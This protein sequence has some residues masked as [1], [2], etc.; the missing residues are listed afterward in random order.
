MDADAAPGFARL[1]AALDPAMAIVT[2]AAG[3]ERSGCLVGFHSQCGIDPPR[4]AVW[5]S[6]ANHTYDIGRRA[7]LFAV[8]FPPATEIALAR[9]FGEDTGDDMDKFTRCGWT[10]GPG[11]VPLLDASPVRFVGRALA[12]GTVDA[13]H[14]CLVLE[15]IEVSSADAVAQF[16]PMRFDAVADLHAG[17]APDE[18]RGT[19]G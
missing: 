2:T 18:R 12:L 8:H 10:P 5:L 15:P 7:E 17:H 1:M 16:N 4:Y 11:D 9:L 6:V 14:A 19:S 3:D 13:D